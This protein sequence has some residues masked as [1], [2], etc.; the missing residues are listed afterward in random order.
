MG[1]IWVQND[2][3][4]SKNGSRESVHG[5]DGRGRQKKRGLDIRAKLEGS[6][7]IPNKGRFEIKI[8]KINQS[9]GDMWH[10]ITK[11]RKG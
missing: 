6:K 7:S 9:K 10:K 5:L 2:V 4:M 8:S 1:S 3:D 11:I